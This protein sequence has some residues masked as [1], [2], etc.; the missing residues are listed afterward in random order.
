MIRSRIG[1]N[2][3]WLCLKQNCVGVMVLLRF[4]KEV[5][6]LNII[7]SNI[8]DRDVK[9]MGVRRKKCRGGQKHSRDGHLSES[10]SQVSVSDRVTN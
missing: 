7:L 3:E 4:R 1:C 5:I 8:L 10:Y 9:S 6:L 2:V